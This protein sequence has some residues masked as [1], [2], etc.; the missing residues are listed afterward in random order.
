VVGLDIAG[1]REAALPDVLRGRS[2]VK[3]CFV[4]DGERFRAYCQR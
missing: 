1:L 4:L 3:D 2:I